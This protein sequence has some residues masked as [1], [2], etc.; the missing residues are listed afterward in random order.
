MAWLKT[1][2]LTVARSSHKEPTS[3]HIKTRRLVS[4]R[5]RGWVLHKGAGETYVGTI[6]LSSTGFIV[7]KNDS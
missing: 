5:V 2:V 7:R 4:R 6:G 1:I 3:L